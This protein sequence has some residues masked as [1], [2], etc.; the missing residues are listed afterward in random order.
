LT[1]GNVKNRQRREKHIAELLGIIQRGRWVFNGVLIVF[2]RDGN[3]IEVSIGFR[4]SKEPGSRW[5]F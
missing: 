2:D 4:R 3:L 1:G 5:R